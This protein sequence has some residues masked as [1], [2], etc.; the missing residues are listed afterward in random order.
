VFHP[1]R[2]CKSK[3]TL[4]SIEAVSKLMAKHKDICLIISGNGDSVDFENERPAFKACI[5]SMIDDLAVSDNILFIAPS[6]E[7]MAQYMQASDVI[8]YPTIQPTG[9]AFG[10]GPVEGMACGKPVIVTRSGGLVESGQHGINGFVLEPDERLSDNLAEH[11]DLLLCNP[12]IASYYGTNGRELA[13]ERFDAKKMAL[14]MEDLY[15]RLVNA[16][17]VERVDRM[18]SVIKPK[19]GK[20]GVRADSADRSKT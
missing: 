6:N 3:G 16:H 10:I 17:I 11:I 15:H 19:A 4:H 7:E 9:E 20:G 8:L 13:L 14:K 2:A 1:A 5:K 12:E 18:D